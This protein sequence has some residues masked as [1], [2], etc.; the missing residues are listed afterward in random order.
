MSP[1]AWAVR[2]LKRYADFSGRSP[3]AEYWWFV[4]FEWLAI[5]A[6]FL[7]SVAV[8]GGSK[9]T[10]PLFGAFIVPFVIGFLGLIIPN[11]AVQVRRLHDQDRSGWFILLFMIPYVGG[12]IGFV[13][14]LIPGTSGPNR[15]GP[16]PYEDD[17]LEE[18]FA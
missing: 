8:A 13:F 5:A 9:E 3:R 7:L 4:L 14:M 15:F 1:I 12:L 10:N 2:P 16:D 17:Y 18:V 11:I 6:L